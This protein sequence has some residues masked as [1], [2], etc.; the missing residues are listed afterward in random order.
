MTAEDITLS[1]E[2]PPVVITARTLEVS[3]GDSYVTIRQVM[4]RGDEWTVY[5]SD[6]RQ[7]GLVGK[8]DSAPNAATSEELVP[9]AADL[10]TRRERAR[11]A[12]RALA[13]VV[14]DKPHP[15]KDVE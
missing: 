6:G 15:V 7:M 3:C 13:Q 4:G 10:V 8:V 9:W 2:T 5:E 11:M 1:V 12:R 14:D